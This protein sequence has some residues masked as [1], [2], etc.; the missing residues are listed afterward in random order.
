MSKHL[1]TV[2]RN[3]YLLLYTQIKLCPAK[4]VGKPSAPHRLWNLPSALHTSTNKLCGFV[5]ARSSQRSSHIQHAAVSTVTHS[6]PFT[7]GVLVSLAWWHVRQKGHS[8]R[9]IHGVGASL[10]ARAHKTGLLFPANTDLN[11]TSMLRRSK[12]NRTEKW[13]TQQ[14]LPATHIQNTS[15]VFYCISI[16]FCNIQIELFTF[17]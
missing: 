4:F 17:F 3:I 1:C 15:T 10:H 11:T 7:P 12:T 5:F 14:L 8:R 16:R 9:W 13:K 6:S 2:K